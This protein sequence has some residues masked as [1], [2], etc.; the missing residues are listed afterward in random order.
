MKLVILKD[1]LKMGI[2]AV[3]RTAGHSLSLPILNNVLLS[4]E[5]NFLNLVTTNLEIAI[6][7]WSLSKTE[8][9]GKTVIPARF[10][11][12]LINLF[13]KQS[14]TLETKGSFFL[15]SCENQEAQLKCFNPEDF[16]LLPQ[17][18]NGDFVQVNNA[19][20]L[21][22]LAQVADIA[23]PSSSRPE[24]SGVFLVF[25]KDLVTMVATDSFRLA[26]KKL[27]FE[28]EI[29]KEY[30]LIVPQ[31]T[32]RELINILSEKKGKLSIYFSPNQIMFEFPMA[33]VSHPQVQIISR[34]IEGEYPDYQEIIPKK[35]ET[36]ITLSKEDFLNQLKA[37]G[38]F[39]G[40]VNEVKFKIEPKK[41]GM[42]IFSQNPEL[43]QSQSFIPGKTKGERV[44]ISFNWRFLAEGLASIKSSEVIFELNGEEGPAL[45]KP[46][47]DLNY[48]YVAMPI[49]S[50]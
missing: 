48:L 23:S 38:L 47:A 31:K 39:C 49:K 50:P 28:K 41:E 45:L 30:S 29:E 14:I 22:G 32:V 19:P 2:N 18:K 9:E 34:L 16:P 26:E 3:E 10:F 4:T 27:F 42:E 17:I 5:K 25:K 36:Q 44:E 43:G 20:F 12:N 6:S 21:E 1:N 37:A 46:A 13:P 24:I 40:K 35:Y 7:W 8:R 15:L 33:E 11:S